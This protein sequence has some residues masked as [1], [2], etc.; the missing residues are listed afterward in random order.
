MANDNTRRRNNESSIG[1]ITNDNRAGGIRL[2]NQLATEL[3]GA[4]E[5]HRTWIDS[6]R[7]RTLGTTFEVTGRILTYGAYLA[8]AYLGFTGFLDIRNGIAAGIYAI[9]AAIDG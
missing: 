1:R 2:L 4:M 7:A 3:L 9:P 5:D 8:L 6:A